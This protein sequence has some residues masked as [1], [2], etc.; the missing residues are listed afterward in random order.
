MQH[1]ASTLYQY[2]PI[3]TPKEPFTEGMSV[4]YEVLKVSRTVSWR[5]QMLAMYF[6]HQTLLPW[7]TLKT[8]SFYMVC[9]GFVM[10][11]CVAIN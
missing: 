7:F 11:V 6:F 4:L 3:I 8:I 5:C 10:N 9:G 1:C 2:T